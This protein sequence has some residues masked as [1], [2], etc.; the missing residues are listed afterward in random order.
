MFSFHQ[1]NEKSS[2]KVQNNL[3][4]V[5]DVVCYVVQKHLKDEGKSCLNQPHRTKANEFTLAFIINQP[6]WVL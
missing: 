3:F 4:P 5:K 6:D 2:G 1:R